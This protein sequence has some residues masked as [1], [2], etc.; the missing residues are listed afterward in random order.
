MPMFN[1]VLVANRGEIAIRIMR[2]LRRLGIRSI[3]IYSEAD[4]EALHLALAD[5]AML[6]GPADA[7]RSYLD[8]ERVVAA[9]LASGAQA[10]HPGYGFLSENAEFAEACVRAGLVFIG[11]H[12]ETIRE[13]GDKRAA[14]EVAATA[15]VPIVPGFH[16]ADAS[17]E[18]LVR[19]VATI[20]YPVIIKPAAGGGGKGMRVVSAAH[21]V[22]DALASAHR[23]ARS[24]FGDDTLLLERYVLNARHIEVQ[25]IG[26][27]AGD[28]VHLGDR[29]CSLQR[30]HQKVIEEAPAPLLPDA[31]RARIHADA[32]AIAKSVNYRGVGTVEFVVD[33]GDPST[34]Y[35]LEM[36]TRLQVEHPV[37]E[38]VTGLDLVELQLR[39]AAG[40]GI[41]L[42]QEQVQVT[43]HA[44]EARIYAEDGHH[45]F[46]P[47]SG[48]V[49]TYAE[50]PWVRIDSGITVGSVIG[51]SYDPLMLKVIAWGHDRTEAFDALDASLASTVVLGVAHNIG[52]LRE[53]ANEAIVRE[54][55][56]TTGLIAALG[57][58]DKSVPLDDHTAAAA[59][60]AWLEHDRANA[61]QSI[62]TAAGAWRVGGYAPITPPFVDDVGQTYM[63]TIVGAGSEQRVVVGDGEPQLAAIT[64][65]PATDQVVVVSL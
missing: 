37:T 47:A 54:G 50:P 4:R 33:A 1:T 48:T 63:P 45:G 25:I 56:M 35:F 21:E 43:G 40:E 3:A 15:G 2:T 55:T 12:S 13:M 64:T 28:V 16:G 51:T 8:I 52:V 41:P 32:V 31:T 59:A 57:L 10:V 14:K 26:D 61:P 44:V 62:W 5:E 30:R 7:R 24:A 18:D 22:A 23:E 36:N 34:Y 19:H 17:D 6:V 49:L 20:G 42:T 38:M 53:L 9:A 11:P 60:L 29:D 65:S 27:G 58:G 39:V 46:L